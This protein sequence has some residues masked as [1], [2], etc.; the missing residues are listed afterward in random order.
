MPIFRNARSPFWW[1]SITIDGKRV[2][3]STGVVARKS[4]RQLAQQI[5]SAAVGQARTFGVQSIT[6]RPSV[7][8]EFAETVFLPWVKNTHSLEPK[9]KTYYQTGWRL[10]KDTPLADKRMNEITKAGIETTN[11][12]HSNYTANTALCTL[13]RMYGMAEENDLI[14]FKIPTIEKRK[15]WGRSLAMSVSDAVKIASHMDGDP[16]DALIVIRATGLRPKEGY[17]M[18]WENIH[19]DERY[20][21]NPHGKTSTSKRPAPLMVWEGLDPMAVL[22]RRHM[23]Q[24]SPAEGWVF[25]SRAKCGHMVSITKAFGIARKAAGLP[26]AL[27]LYTARHGAG[28][29]LGA[30]VSLKQV[31]DILGHADARTAMKYQHPDVAKLQ[32]Q[33]DEARTNG[34]IM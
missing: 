16:R 29:D 11:F 31:M 23:E 12:P 30:V 22:K 26:S 18:R 3:K 2:R 8:R 15:V 13:R 28:T 21:L 34:R 4:N 1:Y 25:P 9:T 19:W 24:G 32:G 6:Q 5:E 20:Y 33:L 10:L 7:L 17:G 14:S 27:C